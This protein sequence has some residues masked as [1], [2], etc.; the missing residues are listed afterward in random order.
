MCREAGVSYLLCCCRGQEAATGPDKR[1]RVDAGGRFRAARFC[2]DWFH[3]LARSAF[4]PR[5]VL[6]RAQTPLASLLDLPRLRSTADPGGSSKHH[7][8]P[9]PRGVC[10]TM[11]FTPVVSPPA[12]ERRK[13]RNH[14]FL[15]HAHSHSHRDND[16]SVFLLRNG[17][18]SLGRESV[19]LC[20]PGARQRKEQLEAEGGTAVPPQVYTLQ[21]FCPLGARG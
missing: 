1:P 16:R 11:I 18:S 15:L 19:L 4:P 13:S 20:V 12:V 9:S 6:G 3:T 14:G 17:A 10:R 7:D 21:S 8:L 2:P 5:S